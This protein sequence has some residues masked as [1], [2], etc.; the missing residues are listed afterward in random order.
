MVSVE[1]T[2]AIVTLLVT[3]PPSILVVWKCFSGRRSESR[4]S[5]IELATPPT[6]P[7]DHDALLLCLFILQL[8][9]LQTQQ[10]HR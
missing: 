5:D 3:C 9:A 8:Q 6:L 2:I 10:R 4:N 1:A 7:P